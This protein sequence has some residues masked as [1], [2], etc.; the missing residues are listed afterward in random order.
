M[1]DKA[2]APVTMASTFCKVSL[3]NK[4]PQAQE[5][6]ICTDI[7]VAIQRQIIDADDRGQHMNLCRIVGTGVNTQAH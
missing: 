1:S 2:A 6:L 3:N 7:L 4:T 5:I